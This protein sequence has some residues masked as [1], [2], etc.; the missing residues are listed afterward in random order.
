MLI[1]FLD[2]SDADFI[3]GF[4]IKYFLLN[5][6]DHFLRALFGSDV[7]LLFGFGLRDDPGN[8][9]LIFLFDFYDFFCIQ[10]SVL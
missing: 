1:N 2:L 9:F 4:K 10:R 7:Y 3:N 5:G 6:G 8:V